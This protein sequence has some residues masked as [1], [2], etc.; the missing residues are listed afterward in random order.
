MKKVLKFALSTFMVFLLFSCGNKNT[1]TEEGKEIKVSI[2]Q[3]KV[4]FKDQFNQLAQLY[5]DEH[6]G[7]KIEIETVGGGDDYGAA[8]KTKFG[9]GSEPTIFNV[10]GPQDVKDWMSKLE[11][12]T[13]A[14]VTKS[15]IPNLLTGVTVDG[16][17][18]GV[19]Y[20]QEGY[21]LIYNK[22][23]LE[24]AG[25][26]PNDLMT[27]EALKKA[28]EKLDSMKSELGIDAVFAFPGKETWVSGLHLSNVFISPEFDGDIMKIFEAKKIDF[29]YQDQF[30][31][32]LD[33]QNNY[34][35]KPTVSLDYSQQ[36][37][38][39]FSLG[40]VVFIQQGNWAFGS[41]EGVDSELAQ[42][43]GMI[44]IPVDGVVEGKLPVGVPMYWAI[45]KNQDEATKQAAKDFL[46]WMYTSETGKKYVV[47]EFKFI[48][49][50]KGYEDKK[51]VDPLSQTVYNYS[52]DGNIINW[53]FMGYPTSWGM[54]SL[55]TEIQKYISGNESFEELI[56]NA[57]HAWEE[58]RK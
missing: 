42:N 58:A 32:I 4:E 33:L 8:L 36:V 57:K 9:S 5:M 43:I 1:Q 39:L 10:G 56:K 7:V 49:A 27:Y 3:F 6:P 38:K 45:N 51:I 20:N 26:N 48:P 13:D 47:D 18:Y 23:L 12:L 29:K 55:G 16:K 52:K 37:E 25:I 41:I 22:A 40:K 17:V 19:P 46:N 30:K 14:D 54:E 34:S 44:P 28:V 11:D 53:L 21:G 24:K 15:A 31:K 35:V 2:F 50:Y